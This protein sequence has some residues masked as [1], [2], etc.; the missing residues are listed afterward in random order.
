M[1]PVLCVALYRLHERIRQRNARQGLG[2]EIWLVL[3][4]EIRIEFWHLTYLRLRN[5]TG[6]ILPDLK[7]WL[8]LGGHIQLIF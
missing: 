6:R 4:F 5:T 2:L 7:F 1:V 8:Q 3:N